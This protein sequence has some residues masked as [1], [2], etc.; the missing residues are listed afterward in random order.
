ML[1]KIPSERIALLDILT[2]EWIVKNQKS[3]YSVTPR[4]NSEVLERMKAYQGDSMLKKAAMR[5]FV[6]HLDPR[7]I[8]ELKGEFQKLD[9]NQNGFIMVEELEMALEKA[10]MKMSNRKVKDIVKQIDFAGNGR[11]NYT[12]FIA[13]TIN[14]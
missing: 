12:E 2:H 13:A 14:A 9:I 1:H 3:N 8:L 5:L 7:K 6:E 4:I 11:I 10:N